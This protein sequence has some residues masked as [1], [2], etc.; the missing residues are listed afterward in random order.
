MFIQRTTL[1]TK[2]LS[3]SE[4]ILALKIQLSDIVKCS[5]VYIYFLD[6]LNAAAQRYFLKILPSASPSHPK[7]TQETF[8]IRVEYFMFS[9]VRICNKSKY[10]VQISNRVKICHKTFLY[11]D[12]LYLKIVICIISFTIIYFF[13]YIC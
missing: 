13:I 6:L 2:I 1:P 8:A 4:M 7:P 9:V 12:Q 11:K 3:M 5:S 10:L